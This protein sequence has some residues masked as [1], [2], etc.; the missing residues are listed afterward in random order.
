MGDSNSM[1]TIVKEGDPDP[2]PNQGITI[3]R[4]IVAPKYFATMGIKLV[5]GRDFTER[6]NGEAPQ[7][8]I[9]NQEFA[10]RFYGSEAEALGKRLHF[11][12]SGSPL[13]EI[14]G[15][16]KDGLYRN[17]YEDRSPYLFLPEYQQYE[18]G[19]TLLVRADSPAN[20]KVVADSMRREVAQLDQRV[21]VYGVLMAEQNLSYAFW[22]PRLAAGMGTA[23][24]VLALLLAMMGVYSV[25]TYTVTQRTREI[26][27]RMA[28]GAQL[29][30]VLRLVVSQGMLLVLVGIGMGLVGAFL[31]TR[32]LASL[33][34]GVTATD[35]VTF[36]G[37]ALIMALVALVACLLPA[38]RAT[39]VDPLVALRYE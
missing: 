32:V 10:R 25:M 34:I 16:A 6:D 14:V 39:K 24:G 36:A 30:D 12:W 13:A 38:R 31:L 37:V 27:I 8:V 29:R 7:V 17:I 3:D 15:I 33:L 28:L 9:V 21:P 26:G 1:I 11:W 2:P 4:S 20:L 22:A 5:R 19:M 35:T 18:S 23:F